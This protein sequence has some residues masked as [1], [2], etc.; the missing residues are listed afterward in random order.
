MTTTNQYFSM[1]KL[2]VP[3]LL[4]VFVFAGFA[5]IARAETT[6]TD[7]LMAIIAS[8]QDKLAQN[9]KDVFKSNLSLGSTGP[10]V[11]A[12]QKRLEGDGFLKMPVGVS[13]GYFGMATKAALENY[14]NKYEVD[15]YSNEIEKEIGTVGRKTRMNLNQTMPVTIDNPIVV[16]GNDYEVWVKDV[17]QA[18]LWKGGRTDK[19]VDVYLVSE[20]GSETYKIG[21][22]L[23]VRA[24]GGLTQGYFIFKSEENPEVKREQKYFVKV[25][26][27]S[28]CD[29]GDR[30]FFY[31]ET[32][33]VKIISPVEGETWK[34]GKTKDINIKWE[35]TNSVAVDYVN[36]A[37][38][39]YSSW[40][41][42][43]YFCP[44]WPYCTGL[45]SS[46]YS[47]TESTLFKEKMPANGAYKFKFPKE[48]WSHTHI[49][50]ITAYTTGE[51]G[52][53]FVVGYDI[54]TVK[55]VK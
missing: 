7:V 9:S 30:S 51:D 19:K 18:I 25:C 37:I 10:E 36:I 38:D 41:G 29:T 14:Q 23:T 26:Q 11:I 16:S 21:K 1:K 20:S 24:S 39:G 44:Q 42:G 48:N 15:K 45:T 3:V 54:R 17:E 13:K 32:P 40:V 5:P 34:T 55:V 47:P 12:L 35:T 2:F 22:D 33:P 6:Q 28:N 46:A 4:G 31:T 52:K 49:I 8:L 43:H 53:A 27:G 50:K